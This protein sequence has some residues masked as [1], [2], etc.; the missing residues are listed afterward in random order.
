[1]QVFKFGGASVNDA[2]G[3]KN[4]AYVLQKIGYIF[5]CHFLRSVEFISDK[6]WRF[7]IGACWPGWFCRLARFWFVYQ[8][9][10]RVAYVENH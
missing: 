2:E 7:S 8:K 4:L 6:K 10:N 1:M 9:F 5:E 3:V